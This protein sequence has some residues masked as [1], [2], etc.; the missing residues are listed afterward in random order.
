MW[1]NHITAWH[2]V[3]WSN[4]LWRRSIFEMATLIQYLHFLISTNWGCCH[5]LNILL[6]WLRFNRCNTQ[7]FKLFL[8][9]NSH[10][11]YRLTVC[12]MDIDDNIYADNVFLI[13]QAVCKQSDQYPSWMSPPSSHNNVSS[14]VNPPHLFLNS[15]LAKFSFR[16]HKNIFPVFVIYHHYP[17]VGSHY[18]ASRQTTTP[19]SRKVNTI[20]AD[21]LATEGAMSSAAIAL[22]WIT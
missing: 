9:I 13:I 22:I 16:N 8:L 14:I 11:I 15:W 1:E 17:V 21:D 20:A 7:S 4:V 5:S 18:P 6:S 19:L 2:L 12:Y 3:V 10:T